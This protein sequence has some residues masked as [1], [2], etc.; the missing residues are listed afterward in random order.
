MINGRVRF[1][2]VLGLLGKKFGV[3]EIAR[4]LRGQDTLGEEKAHTF[5]CFGKSVFFKYG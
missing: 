5:F 4:L 1:N 3:F 2:P